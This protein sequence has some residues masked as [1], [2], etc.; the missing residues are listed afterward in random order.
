[1]YFENEPV[2]YRQGF[3]GHS[4]PTARLDP[5]ASTQKQFER[6]LRQDSRL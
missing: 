5:F 1:M 6:A 3:L 4:R 2:K